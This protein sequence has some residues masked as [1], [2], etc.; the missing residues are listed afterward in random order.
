MGKICTK[1]RP[2]RSQKWGTSKQLLFV[3]PNGIIISKYSVLIRRIHGYRWLE[4]SRK[5]F[6]CT[7]ESKGSVFTQ[8]YD[9]RSI[10]IPATF[11][12]KLLQ[13]KT[14]AE[15]DKPQSIP[16]EVHYNINTTSPFTWGHYKH[17]FTLSLTRTIRGSARSSI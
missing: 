14:I 12:L 8:S 4:I 1:W 6:L 7:A 15:S 9:H 2:H 3:T 11:F 17:I 5:I 10:Q 16:G 13:L